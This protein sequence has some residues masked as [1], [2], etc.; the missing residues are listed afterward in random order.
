[1]AEGRTVV[2]LSNFDFAPREVRRGI[3]SLYEVIERMAARGWEVHYLCPHQLGLPDEAVH[4]GVY[5][6]R[7]RMPF[8]LWRGR[9][10]SYLPED[11]PWRRVRVRL[12]RNVFWFSF[13][14]FA[15]SSLLRLLRCVRCDLLYAN[16]TTGA[17]PVALAAVSAGVPFVV[18]IY[19]LPRSEGLRFWL[20]RFRDYFA[21][22]LPAC[23][24]ILTDDGGGAK[25][26][27]LKL[28]VDESRLFCWPNGVDFS[29]RMPEGEARRRLEE[30]YGVSPSSRVVLSLGR[31][32]R[33]KGVDALVYASARVI[34]RAKDVCFLVANDGDMRRELEEWTRRQ[35]LV[36]KVYFLGTVRRGELPVLLN[37]ADVCV[38]LARDTNV[39]NVVREAMVCGKAI[40][41]RR[42]DPVEGLLRH[43]REG[44]MVDAVTPEAVA[45]GLLRLLGDDDLRRRLGE[46]ALR[47]AEECFIDWDERARM[48]MNLLEALIDGTAGNR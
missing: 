9:P 32:T 31:V 27:A 18:R 22:L 10:L 40:L 35:G 43:G 12:L 1:M 24:F 36:G 25:D 8:A 33:M 11:T 47:R 23:A 38:A 7:F 19:G 17:Y 29:L 14:L 26:L 39:S 34:E 13:Q 16:F 2:V 5:V 41:T 44:W 3:P 20:T 42:R 21:F 28:G 15:A 45:E 46:G 30:E 37:A 4:H 6:H 48:E